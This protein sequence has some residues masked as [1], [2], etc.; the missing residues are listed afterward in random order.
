MVVLSRPIPRLA[1][2]SLLLGSAGCDETAPSNPTPTPTPTI[3]D[4]GE[5]TAIIGSSGGTL[6][7][8]GLMVSVPA[9]ALATDTEIKLTVQSDASGVRGLTS[10]IV[11]RSP[12]Y[13]LTP[14]GTTFSSPVT[15]TLPFEGNATAVYRLDD[16]VDPTWDVLGVVP[17][18]E[19]GL[20]TFETDTFSVFRL[21]DSPLTASALGS[22][23]WNR[24][25]AHPDFVGTYGTTELCTL[26][27]E[28]GMLLELQRYADT[29]GTDCED[30]VLAY[31]GSWADFFD[32]ADLDY[33]IEGNSSLTEPFVMDFYA[34][35]T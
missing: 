28:S 10:G 6:A 4:D 31:Y 7:M 29:Y 9:G 1:A 18:I 26:S 21:M 14:H 5:V 25:C 2:V 16:E 11:A 32:S 12:L 19:N 34:Y 33:C 24:D 8:E 3:P 15:V 35:C 27:W 17:S 23:N 30:A 13:I 20:A 22:C